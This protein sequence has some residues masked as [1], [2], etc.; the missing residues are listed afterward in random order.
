MD[1]GKTQLEYKESQTNPT[2]FQMNN[3]TTLKGMVRKELI[4]TVVGRLQDGPSYP[5]SWLLCPCVIPP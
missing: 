4:L 1:R 5:A 2:V 3:I